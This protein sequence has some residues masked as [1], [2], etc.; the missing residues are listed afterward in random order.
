MPSNPQGPQPFP[1]GGPGQQPCPGQPAALATKVSKRPT[2]AELEAIL[3]D[4]NPPSVQILPNGEVVPLDNPNAPV[5]SRNEMLA[6]GHASYQKALA[7]HG[8]TL[9][10]TEG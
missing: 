3:N 1:C 7:D 10:A 9:A 4:P 8:I 2:I 5:Y 6:H